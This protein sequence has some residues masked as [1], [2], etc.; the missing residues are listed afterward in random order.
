[1]P[2]AVKYGMARIH[3]SILEGGKERNNGH[4]Q[5]KP[6]TAARYL[7]PWAALRFRLLRPGGKNAIIDMNFPKKG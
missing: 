1:M 2:L 6:H 4:F 7:S 5:K 3:F